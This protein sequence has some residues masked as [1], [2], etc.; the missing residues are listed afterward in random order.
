MRYFAPAR[1]FLIIN[2]ISSTSVLA[3]D[4]TIGYVVAVIMILGFVLLAITS[5]AAAFVPECPFYSPFSTVVELVFKCFRKLFPW[6]SG[7]RLWLPIALSLGTGAAV[8]SATLKYS[9]NMFPLVFIPLTI[10]FSYAA[11]DEDEEDKDNLKRRRPQKYSLPHF[12][13]GGF[14]LIGSILAAAG[15]FTGTQEIFIILYVIGMSILFIGGGV[16]RYLAKSSKKTRVIDAMAWLLNSESTPSK[17]EPL[18]QRIGQV[19]FDKGDENGYSHYRARLLESLMPLLSSLITSPRTKLLHDPSQLKDLEIYVSFL[20]HLS[21]FEDDRFRDWKF[22]KHLGEDAKS[23][24]VLEDTLRKKL[25]ELIKYSRSDDLTAAAGVVLSKFGFDENGKKF[26]NGEKF[27]NEE[28]FKLPKLFQFSRDVSDTSS[29]TTLTELE[30]G[31]PFN[32]ANLKRQS[33]RKKGYNML[34]AV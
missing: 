4:K 14:V 29:I 17:I 18:L 30:P 26:K 19:T 12:A 16:A 21:D 34:N 25:V 3:L 27:K 15:Y 9:E 31:P 23:H 20:A 11:M 13:L 32:G 8:A 22:L 2:F 10:T 1:L 5:L 24:P 33:R 7:H 6:K 28:K